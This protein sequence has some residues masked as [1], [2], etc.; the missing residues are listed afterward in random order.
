AQLS[1]DLFS[2]K[3]LPFEISQPKVDIR[4]LN[5]DAGVTRILP[6]ALVISLQGRLKVTHQE[7]SVT[8]PLQPFRARDAHGLTASHH[9]LG[10]LL[11]VGSLVFPEQ[12][13]K[14]FFRNKDIANVVSSLLGKM[15]SK[16]VQHILADLAAVQAPQ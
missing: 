11:C 5:Q 15:V 6:Q 14:V 8:E 9:A 10:K 16:S 7:R 3:S 4:Q 2:I 1:I 12:N 13:E